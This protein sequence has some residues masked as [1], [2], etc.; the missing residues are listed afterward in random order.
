MTNHLTT[1]WA[2]AMYSQSKI[3]EKISKLENPKWDKSI[4]SNSVKPPFLF[5]AIRE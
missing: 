5:N 1:F 2:V 4:M 3:N